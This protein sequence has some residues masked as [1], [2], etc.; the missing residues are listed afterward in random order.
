MRRRGSGKIF[1][2]DFTFVLEDSINISVSHEIFH[3]FQDGPVFA[4]DKGQ[5]PFEMALVCCRL[6]S[7]DDRTLGKRLFLQSDPGLFFAWIQE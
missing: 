7:G 1:Q 3:I 2:K 5:A 6:L 4:S